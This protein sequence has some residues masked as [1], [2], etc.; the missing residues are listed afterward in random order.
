MSHG[1]TILVVDDEPAIRRFLR[2]SLKGQ[3]YEI[4]EASTGAEALARLEAAKP[5]LVMID[6]GLPDTDGLGLLRHIR[7]GSALPV[8]VLTVRSGERDKVEALDLGAD[9]YVTKP[10]AV[11]ELLARVRTALRHRYQ[12]EGVPPIYRHESL[13]VDLV[14]RHVRVG[15]N[16]VRLSPKEYDLLAYLVRY[17]GRVITHQQLLREVWGPA[18]GEEVQYLRVYMRQLRQKLEPDPTQPRHLLTE[19]GVGYRLAEQPTE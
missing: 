5:D 9:D 6:L 11:G 10:F 8:I 19:P 2:T 17:S 15:G 4:V 3:G 18:Q 1:A 13:E 14:R 16:E 12:A 7:A